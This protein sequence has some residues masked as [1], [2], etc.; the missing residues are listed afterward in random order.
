MNTTQLQAFITP[1]VSQFLDALDEAFPERSA[2]V[3]ENL[4][5]LHQYGGKRDLIRYLL[6]LAKDI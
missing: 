3:H 2:G 5:Q 1:Q 4:Q 6:H